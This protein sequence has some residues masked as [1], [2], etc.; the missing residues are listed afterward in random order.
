M[1]KM[2]RLT[3]FVLALAL[4]AAVLLLMPA[5][6]ALAAE[7][8]NSEYPTPDATLAEYSYVGYE[9][10]KDYRYDLAD[11]VFD[12]IALGKSVIVASLSNKVSAT[13]SPSATANGYIVCLKD[14]DL[15]GSGDN[16]RHSM[17]TSQQLTVDLSGHTMNWYG[18]ISTGSSGTDNKTV[19]KIKN[20]TA[21]L[22]GG[23]KGTGSMYQLV[24]LRGGSKL[25]FDNVDL[26]NSGTN[27]YSIFI[28]DNGG[29]VYMND[30]LLK[31][32]SGKQFA[33][34]Y[35]SA[36]NCTCDDCMAKPSLQ[37]VQDYHFNGVTVSGSTVLFSC[38]PTAHTSKDYYNVRLDIRF[39]GNCSLN[40]TGK[41]VSDIFAFSSNDA[42][43]KAMRASQLDITIEEGTAFSDAAF[44]KSGLAPKYTLTVVDKNGDELT[45]YK[46]FYSA[47]EK[48]P[49]M[50]ARN[51]YTVSWYAYDGTLLEAI[52]YAEGAVPSHS[53]PEHPDNLT[54]DAEGNVL[55]KRHDGWSRTEGA[56][57]AEAITAVL[58]DT[59]YYAVYADELAAVYTK[60]S[61]GNLTAG[62]RDADIGSEAI[63]ALANGSK[64]YLNTDAT[65][66]QN[67]STPN[68]SIEL[69]G[70]TLTLLGAAL[71]PS[72]TMAVSGGTL[73]ADGVCPFVIDGGAMLTLN[74]VSVSSIDAVIAEINNGV[75]EVVG[76]EL[77]ASSATMMG[78]IAAYGNAE[79]I[80]RGASVR[81]RNAFGSSAVVYAAS[82]ASI[83]SVSVTSNGGTDPR[84][85]VDGTLIYADGD[86]GYGVVEATVVDTDIFHLGELVATSAETADF[87]DVIIRNAKIG[88]Q[89]SGANFRTQNGAPLYT[90]LDP[91]TPVTDIDVEFEVYSSLTVSKEFTLN[92][93]IP[94]GSPV[95]DVVVGG[96]SYF[97]VN[98]LDSYEKTVHEGV[99]CYRVECGSF[100]A[101]NAISARRVQYV[102][103]HE[104]GR[105]SLDS[106]YS[107]VEYCADVLAG[108]YSD[109][110]KTL[111]LDILCYI[112]EGYDFFIGSGATEE[113]L[114]L[115]D[116]LIG[117]Y[118][119]KEEI[120]ADAADLSALSGLVSSVQFAAND[121]I[122]MRI[123]LTEAAKSEKIRIYYGTAAALAVNGT[124]ADFLEIDVPL[125]ALTDTIQIVVGETSA[126]Y[127]FAAYV[128]AVADA[129][130]ESCPEL[131]DML[132]ATLRLG[133]SARRYE[134]AGLPDTPSIEPDFEF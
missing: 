114:K 121:R 122:T 12:G 44:L 18:E 116:S 117:D 3:S 83:V 118:D 115:V 33:A 43:I 100:T 80:I 102:I 49:D 57:A 46:V 53:A 38:S 76:G 125:F 79:V 54:M 26:I 119:S 123:A 7:A 78:A 34:I 29:S 113:E 21:L 39:T 124:D 109:I 59:A 19:L 40:T 82:G 101:K 133:K 17:G 72:G 68:V 89:S 87:V 47:L 61:G 13:F 52:K 130:S 73:L 105:Y 16:N 5:D 94:E 98:S 126:E 56:T 71:I 55:L 103:E 104:G 65:L 8:G 15:K 97:D 112:R 120:P 67:I 2:R 84:F 36:L 106:T 108:D 41:A 9:S 64:L 91:N 20:G 31:L 35:N 95:V 129:Y 58:A 77:R 42:A 69:Q 37:R 14:V 6:T 32:D 45:D 4:I 25:Y 50:I 134:G 128:A 88:R 51:E 92:F 75:I 30:C 24:A 28:Y 93:Y 74:G 23:K 86:V 48:Y 70:N 111:M 107:I 96:V 131:C 90:P 99:S 85:N 127:S 81:T 1:K 10:E 22:H 60:D 11:G 66:S 110:T 62:F 63:A 27:R 132:A